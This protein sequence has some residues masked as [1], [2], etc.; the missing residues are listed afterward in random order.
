MW[1]QIIGGN[2]AQLHG[3]IIQENVTRVPLECA[4]CIAMF[5]KGDRLMYGNTIG[6][7]LVLVAGQLFLNSFTFRIAN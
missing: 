3:V 2:T 5:K 6:I 4:K 7:P 1:R